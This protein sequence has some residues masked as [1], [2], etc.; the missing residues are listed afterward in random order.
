MGIARDL[1]SCS[2][3]DDAMVYAEEDCD[4]PVVLTALND[5]GVAYVVRES[6]TDGDSWVRGLSHYNAAEYTPRGV[7][8]LVS[9]A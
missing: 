5:S 2:Y 1:S 4:A 8:A 7:A 9:R 3:A 6:R